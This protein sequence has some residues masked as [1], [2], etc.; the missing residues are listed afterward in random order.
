MRETSIDICRNSF[1]THSYTMAINRSSIQ[2]LFSQ[3][4]P[5]GKGT[6]PIKLIILF[7]H[8]IDFFV[9]ILFVALKIIR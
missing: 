1:V 9:I 8:M 5:K 7:S 2:P 4:M 6:T 3:F